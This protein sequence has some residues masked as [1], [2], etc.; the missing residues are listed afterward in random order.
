MRTDKEFLDA[1]HARAAG[2]ERKARARRARAIGLGATLGGLA[3]VILLA[4]VMPSFE[5]ASLSVEASARASLFAESG[6]LGYVVIGVTAFLLGA[7]VTVLCYRLRKDR[8]DG[9]G[10]P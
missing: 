4:L 9:D 6:A 8:D 5:A 1:M 2:I 10:E 7:A 3:A